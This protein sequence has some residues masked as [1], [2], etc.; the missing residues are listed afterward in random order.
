MGLVRIPPVARH[1]CLSHYVTIRLPALIVL[2]ALLSKL[3]PCMTEN[4]LAS[5]QPVT[6]V[7]VSSLCGY[8]WRA[9]RPFT[10]RYFNDLF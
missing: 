4:L 7:N 2:E 8:T 9:Q 6:A 1:A 3:Q 5:W 10:E